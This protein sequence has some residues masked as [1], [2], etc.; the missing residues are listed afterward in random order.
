MGPQLRIAKRR[1]L[2]SLFLGTS[3]SLSLSLSRKQARP[4]SMAAGTQVGAYELGHVLGE[5]QFGKVMEAVNR[6]G[7]RFAVKVIRKSAIK[8]GKDVEAV[9]KEVKFMR[10]LSHPNILKMIEALEDAENLYFVLELAKGGD[11]FDSILKNGGF[12]EDTARQF[13]VQLINGLEH[14]HAQ[15]IIHRDLKPENLLLTLE[16]VLK[17]SDFGLSNIVYTPD[18]LLRTHCGSEK[19]AAP[20][21][22]QNKDPYIGF[23]IDVWSAGVILY[24]MVGG[25]FPF[26][27]ATNSCNLYTAHVRGEFVWPKNFSPELV[28]LLMHMFAI[29]PNERITLPQIR[30]HAWFEAITLAEARAQELAASALG[31]MAMDEALGQMAMDEETATEPEVY[32][33]FDPDMMTDNS[34]LDEEPQVYRCIGDIGEIDQVEMAVQL[35]QT[36]QTRICTEEMTT[37]LASHEVVDKLVRL[38]ERKGCNVSTEEC[39]D[40]SCVY[41]QVA[42]ASSQDVKVRFMI[43]PPTCH[44]EGSRVAVKRMRG[45]SLD[46]VKLYE[47]IR[48]VLVDELSVC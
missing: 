25:A 13:F 11:L 3:L 45:H 44:G 21:I 22:M 16:H 27:E 23:P 37:A 9:K 30:N 38:L 42:G 7:N 39:L 34:G 40:E 4:E 46:Y 41:A 14:C 24:I 33:T 18:Q 10:T 28:D 26:V 48:D 47:S 12:S 32:R 6:T 1:T 20:E 36:P 8:K 5:G 43:G 29:A 19:Y 15:G 17:I 31:T 35:P 2:P